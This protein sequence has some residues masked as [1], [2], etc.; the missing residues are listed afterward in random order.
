MAN[1]I[2]LNKTKTE[3]IFFHKP[4][5]K[6]PENYNFKLNGLKL[7]HSSHIKYLGIYLDETLNGAF[8]CSILA[9][10]LIR[11]NAMLSKIRHYV[12]QKDLISVYYSI[13]SSH[14]TYGCQIWGQNCSSNHF[15]KIARLKKKAVR[16]IT[17]SGPIDHTE[18]IFKKLN[19]L[20]L[21][22]NISLY[23]CL[24]IHDQ[25]RNLLPSNFDGY[26]TPCSE[27]YEADTRMAA[28]SLFIPSVQSQTYGRQS[29]KLSAIHTWN[30]L[31]ETLNINLLSLSRF[32]LKKH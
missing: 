2:S 8:Q 4:R 32:T 31:C 13:F 15:K 10:K 22:D 16:I 17:F 14:M 5:D 20:K 9:S 11:A 24:L 6:I 26:F 21:K 1:K 27:L 29:I 23:N 25:T 19:R 12:S 18:P 3:L 7:K 30:H 28:G